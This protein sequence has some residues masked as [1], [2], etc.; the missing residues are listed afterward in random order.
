MRSLDEQM[1]D[2]PLN[3]KEVRRVHKTMTYQGGFKEGYFHGYGELRWENGVNYK[4]SR[5]EG[6]RHG[7]GIY[8][9]ESGPWVIIEKTKSTVTTSPRVKVHCR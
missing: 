4:E 2:G 7:C 1:A 3:F 5:N 8:S 9:M 6:R